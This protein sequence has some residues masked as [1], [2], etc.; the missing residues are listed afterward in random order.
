MGEG[1]RASYCFPLLFPAPPRA[2]GRRKEEGLGRESCIWS[3]SR[4]VLPPLPPARPLCPHPCRGWGPTAPPSS[5]GSPQGPPRR[6]LLKASCA[7]VV[8]EVEGRVE[9]ETMGMGVGGGGGGRR[10]CGSLVPCGPDCRDGDRRRRQRGQGAAGEGEGTEAARRREEPERES[11]ERGD[12]GGAARGGS[13]EWRWV[14]GGGSPEPR[15]VS[16]GSVTGAVGVWW[17]STLPCSL[18]APPISRC[19]CPG[20]P[21]QQAQGGTVGNTTLLNRA[22]RKASPIFLWIKD[23][24]SL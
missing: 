16:G 19:L 3:R 22:E 1:A 10:G 9:W 5:A 12:G 14:F 17:G 20:L 7:M 6:E 24:L 23:P 11:W 18:P 4:R 21:S 8:G 13:R 2:T 15:R